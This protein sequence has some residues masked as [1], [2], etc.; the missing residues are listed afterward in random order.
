V[1]QLNV[2]LMVADLEEQTPARSHVD[3]LRMIIL[4]IVV[5]VVVPFVGGMLGG[6]WFLDGSRFR[7]LAADQKQREK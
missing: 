2:G 3:V 6:G 1:D 5:A 7:W 4:V